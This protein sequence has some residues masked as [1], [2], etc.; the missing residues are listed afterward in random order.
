MNAWLVEERVTGASQIVLCNAVLLEF[1]IESGLADAEQACGHELVA[2]EVAQR[3]EDGLLLHLGD[4]ADL[5]GEGGFVLN[6]CVA[7]FE[8]DAGVLKLRGEIAEMQYRAAGEREGAPE[9]VLKLAD[10][11]RPVVVDEKVQSVLGDGVGG[12]V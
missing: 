2:V 5:D 10:V 1:A 9:C 3:G 12:L 11:S 7:V 8:F 6:G 4:G